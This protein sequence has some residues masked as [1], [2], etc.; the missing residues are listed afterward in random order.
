MACCMHAK[1]STVESVHINLWPEVCVV[2]GRG[3][4]APTLKHVLLE[5]A[6]PFARVLLSYVFFRL[7]T[8]IIAVLSGRT[9]RVLGRALPQDSCQL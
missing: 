9:V 5:G 3:D 8:L 1:A 7:C 2:P 6:P 4:A